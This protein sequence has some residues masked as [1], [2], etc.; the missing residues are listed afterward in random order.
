MYSCKIIITVYVLTLSSENC[1]GLWKTIFKVLLNSPEGIFQFF[2]D[3]LLP[4]EFM[5]WYI[6]IFV[7]SMLKNFMFSN[8]DFSNDKNIQVFLNID[9]ERWWRTNSHSIFRNLLNPALVWEN[10]CAYFPFSGL[11]GDCR[12]CQATHLY[13]FFVEERL[14]PL[15]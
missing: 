9:N 8:S 4:C 12:K 14:C 5:L 7:L 15:W 10:D 13:L 6:L 1:F 3:N 2:S 11:S